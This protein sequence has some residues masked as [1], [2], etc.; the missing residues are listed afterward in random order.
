MKTPYP[1]PQGLKT[2]A[3]SNPT[4]PPTGKGCQAE[5]KGRAAGEQKWSAGKPGERAGTGRA[6]SA[7]PLPP[8]TQAQPTNLQNVG[9]TSSVHVGP[10]GADAGGLHAVITRPSAGLNI[11][12]LPTR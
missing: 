7:V 1:Q 4:P 8:L 11:H 6:N 5:G 3:K 10:R 2:G 9:V 12:E